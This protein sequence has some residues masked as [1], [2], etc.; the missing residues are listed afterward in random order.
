[1]PRLRQNQHEKAIGELDGGMSQN[2]AAAAL[3]VIVSTIP[4]L[5]RRNNATES[6]ND[7]LCAPR[8]RF[9]APQQER[10]ICLQHVRDRYWQ[11]THIEANTRGHH[12]NR[13]SDQTVQNRLFEARFKNRSPVH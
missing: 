11:A 12:Q 10:H 9:I 1:M 6:T 5:W 4:C 8:S 3:G 13:I 2:R 7:H